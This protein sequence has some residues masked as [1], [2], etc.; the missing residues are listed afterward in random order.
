MLSLVYQYHNLCRNYSSSFPPRCFFDNG[1]LC[2]CEINNY[3]AE[4]FRYDHQVD[5][6]DQCFS[7]GRCVRGDLRKNDEFVC[8][9]APCHYGRRCQFSSEDFSFTLEQ[10]FTHSLLHTEKST[11]QWA[12]IGI[13]FAGCLILIIG[14]INN[15]FMFITFYRSK[16][17]QTGVGNYLLV[18]SVI[19]QMTLSALAF[20]SIYSVLN[21]TG[22]TAIV[23]V[24]VNKILC[25]SMPFALMSLGQLSYW[26]MSTVAI[27]R[28]YVTW[29]ISGRW[30]KK[31][32]IARWITFTLAA[33]T[34]LINT[35]QIVFFNLFIDT[36][37]EKKTATC[38]VIYPSGFW[39][40]VNQVINYVSNLVPL[41]INILC[42][43]GIMFLI[44]R[45]K[46]LVNR[47]SS[48]SLR[49]QITCILSF[50]HLAPSMTTMAIQTTSL[51]ELS[52]TLRD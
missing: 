42:T 18:G 6:C 51:N 37:I 14:S 25:K 16:F 48:M 38:V 20:R 9:C 45:Q 40:G 34:F 8:I 31:P 33:I 7:Q 11:R 3:R 35:P 52:K 41:L 19:N 13:I 15:L 22:Y 21:V 30:L 43:S 27:E 12:F 44:I 47:K 39:T 24:T 4:C 5:R 23:N 28:L 46:L 29:N 49:K 50:L 26:L 36:T 17:L 2:M 32:R 1:Y 10:L